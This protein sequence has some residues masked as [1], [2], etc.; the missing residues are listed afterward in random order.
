MFE[1]RVSF[2]CKTC[3]GNF[4]QSC[5]HPLKSTEGLFSGMWKSYWC[6]VMSLCG[7]CLLNCFFIAVNELSHFFICF[8]PP[9]FVFFLGIVIYCGVILLKN[10]QT[11]ALVA[12]MKTYSAAF[13]GGWCQCL[14]CGSGWQPG[15]S[16]SRILNTSVICELERMQIMQLDLYKSLVLCFVVGW[17]RVLFSTC[18]IH[19]LGLICACFFSQDFSSER[20]TCRAWSSH[21]LAVSTI[22]WK[23]GPLDTFLWNR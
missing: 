12:L 17:G 11:S 23:G 5:Q 16:H 10:N 1:Y 19:L 20:C 6:L 4:R 2:Q 3:L 9:W 15:I 22:H 14:L 18:R 7:F 13:D 8:I 21:K